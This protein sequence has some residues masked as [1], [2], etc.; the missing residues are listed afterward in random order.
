[1]CMAVCDEIMAAVYVMLVLLGVRVIH[2]LTMS[3]TLI[4]G[5]AGRS[6]PEQSVYSTA[7]GPN[8]NPNTNPN[9]NRV[10]N[11]PCFLQLRQFTYLKP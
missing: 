5:Y 8:P 4:P 1:M 7:T 9:S 6:D 11:I 2:S 3:L 10:F